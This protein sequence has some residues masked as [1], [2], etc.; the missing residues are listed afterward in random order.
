MRRFTG[1]N[2]FENQ[3]PL[4]ERSGDIIYGTDSKMSIED[5]DASTST[6]TFKHERD[7]VAELEQENKPRVPKVE[8]AVKIHERRAAVAK[9]SCR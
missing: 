9:A 1:V 8:E 4:G 5:L 2:S 3:M 7:T 6:A